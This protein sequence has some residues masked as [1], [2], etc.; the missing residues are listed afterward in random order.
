[1]TMYRLVRAAS[2]DSAAREDPLRTAEDRRQREREV[3]HQTIHG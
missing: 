1:M 3:H 2:D